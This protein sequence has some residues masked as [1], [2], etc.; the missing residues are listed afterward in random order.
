MFLNSGTHAHGGASLRWFSGFTCEVLRGRCWPPRVTRCCSSRGPRRPSRR[1]LT[2]LFSL[3][4]QS[5]PCML[6][7]GCP[8]GLPRPF[9]GPRAFSGAMKSLKQAQRE[10]GGLALHPWF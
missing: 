3:P 4:L 2:T 1:E 10:L 7:A 8:A 6:S 9:S 5:L